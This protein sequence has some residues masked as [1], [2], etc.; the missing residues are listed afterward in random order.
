MDSI[1][2]IY[3][4]SARGFT[5]KIAEDILNLLPLQRRKLLKPDFFCY[6]QKVESAG[7][8]VD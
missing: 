2:K 6:S 8:L 3:L 5:F 4:G 1:V 7:F